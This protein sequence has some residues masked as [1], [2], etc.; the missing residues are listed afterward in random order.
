MKRTKVQESINTDTGEVTRIEKT[1]TYKPKKDEAF[2]ITFLSGANAVF[3]LS[4]PAD[5]KVL[6]YLCTIAEYNTGMVDFNSIKREGLMKKLNRSSQS[7]T[8]SLH[9]LKKEHLLAG[10]RGIFEINPQ[11]FWR[12]TTD[13][14]RSLLK[15][16]KAELV[17]KFNMEDE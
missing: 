5:I 4:I 15:N 14:R 1:F 10:S 13:E 11:Y 6:S 16:K 9:R 8:N 12:G 2:Y 17:L 7:I 3:N